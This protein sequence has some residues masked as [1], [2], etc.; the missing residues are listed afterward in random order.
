MDTSLTWTVKAGP[1]N[2]VS[3]KVDRMCTISKLEKD[4]LPVALTVSEFVLMGSTLRYL[5][6]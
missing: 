5:P 6:L 3:K 2:I 1:G 4:I